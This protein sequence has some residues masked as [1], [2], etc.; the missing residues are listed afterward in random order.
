M[1]RLHS[2]SKCLINEDLQSEL[3][4]EMFAPLNNIDDFVKFYVDPEIET[5]VWDNGADFA[6]EILYDNMKVLA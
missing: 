4:G 5:I 3:E 2:K 6:P 1:V